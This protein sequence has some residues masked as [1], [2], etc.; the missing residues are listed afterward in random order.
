MEQTQGFWKLLLGG[1]LVVPLV[2]EDGSTFVDANCQFGE[3]A[4][5]LARDFP[6][7]HVIGIGKEHNSPVA[8][9]SNCT[10]VVENVVS[11]TSL[12]SNS[13]QFVQSRDV[14]LSL[15]EEVW[16][17]Y[18]AELYRILGKDGYIQVLEMDPWRKYPESPGAGYKLW[19][20]KV[21]PALANT[22]GVCVDGL[23]GKLLEWAQN[24]GFADIVPIHF[25]IPVGIWEDI[26]YGSPY[27][28]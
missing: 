2:D 11:G 25:E 17:R 19:S 13:C 26:E 27:S 20:D 6:K 21:L 14:S 12:A 10:F 28:A 24:V 16:K 7:A 4:M 23:H 8:K 9:P 5:D 18:L 22:K 1:N 3:Y 15:K